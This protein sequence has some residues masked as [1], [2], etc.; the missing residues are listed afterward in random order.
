[1]KMTEFFAAQLERE[2]AIT[3]RALE[4]VPEGRP[5]W[6]PHE[7]SMPLGYLAQL[8]ATMP[9]W[10]A[11]AIVQDELDLKPSHGGGIHAAGTTTTKAELLKALRRLRGQGAR[12]RSARRPT[13]T[14]SRRSG[15]SSWPAT[16]WRRTRGTRSSPTPSRTS[17][18]TA[19]S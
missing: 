9:G 10:I 14:C 2:A 6:K 11:L 12:V 19:G 17:R 7:K 15:S 1:M 5:D 8:V 16:W 18:T 13:S 3:R 4:R